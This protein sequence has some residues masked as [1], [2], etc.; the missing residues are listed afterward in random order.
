MKGKTRRIDRGQW[1]KHKAEIIRLYE[2]DTLD[3]IKKF[4]TEKRNFPAE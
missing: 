2:V 3:H 4:M 1:R